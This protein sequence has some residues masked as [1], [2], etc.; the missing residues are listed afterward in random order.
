MNLVTVLP[1][2]N[3]NTVAGNNTYIRTMKNILKKTFQ[4]P[5]SEFCSYNGLTFKVY[6]ELQADGAINE[7]TY[8]IELSNGKKIIAFAEEIFETTGTGTVGDPIKVMEI[9]E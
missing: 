4:T 5:H 9:N 6:E 2:R 7:T 8:R 3:T 1:G